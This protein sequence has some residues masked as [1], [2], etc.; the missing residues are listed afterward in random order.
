MAI[1][2]GDDP[3]RVVGKA[4]QPIA[5]RDQERDPTRWRPSHSEEQTRDWETGDSDV[6]EDEV[7]YGY[8]V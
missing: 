7:G 2:H 8:G 6:S 3:T 5:D 1:V 4:S